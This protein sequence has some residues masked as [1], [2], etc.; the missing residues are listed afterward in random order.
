MIPTAILNHLDEHQIGY[1]ILPHARAVT[2]Q[3]VADALEV[4]ERS[5]AKTVVL[6]VDGRLILAVASA[7]DRVDEQAVALALDARDAHLA[8]EAQFREAFGD[9][10]LGAEPPFGRLFGMPML[11][12]ARLSHEDAIIVRAGHH[13]E[14]LRLA[15][16]DFVRLEQ[17][18]VLELSP[19]YP[20]RA[21]ARPPD[22]RR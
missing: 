16:D 8:S 11:A 21:E 22:A 19:N 20:P 5:V 12:D 10:E 17:P 2:A 7:S 3:E 1:E 14:A 15:W 9:C 13:D 18:R 4:P 6:D